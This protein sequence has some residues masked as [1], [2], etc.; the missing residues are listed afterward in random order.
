MAHLETIRPT[1]GD[2]RSRHFL[3]WSRRNDPSDLAKHQ[4]VQLARRPEKSRCN[5][6]AKRS[7]AITCTR[8]Q[9]LRLGL[10]PDGGLS[11]ARAFICFRFKFLG[12][13]REHVHAQF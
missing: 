6:G 13:G 12:K 5:I 9:V 7:H 1:Q 3:V 4:Q 2:G 8:N 11:L 10:H